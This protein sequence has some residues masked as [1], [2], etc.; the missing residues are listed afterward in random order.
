MFLAPDLTGQTENPKSGLLALGIILFGSTLAFIF[1]RSVYVPGDRIHD[2][3]WRH[4]PGWAV[5]LIRRAIEEIEL[6]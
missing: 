6:A 3:L 1:N 5:P 2:T 4:K